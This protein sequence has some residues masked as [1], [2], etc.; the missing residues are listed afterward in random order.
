MVVNIVLLMDAV[1]NV[2][3]DMFK[4]PLVKMDA[5]IVTYH[6]LKT[7]ILIV[8][9]VLE[10]ELLVLKKIVILAELQTIIWMETSVNAALN[11]ALIVVA[12]I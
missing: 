3:L 5:I 8:K 1:M 7:N 6:A 9:L 4:L 10:T 11:T 12:I 2:K